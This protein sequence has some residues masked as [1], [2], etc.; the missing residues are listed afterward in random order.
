[1]TPDQQLF[2]EFVRTV[3][4]GEKRAR[5]LSIEDAREAMGLILDG[6]A[7]R[8][9]GAAFLLAL[10]IKGEDPAEVA[11][12]AQAMMERCAAAPNLPDMAH[13]V[14]VGHP[15]DGREDTFVMGAGAAIVAAAAGGRVV[16]HGAPRVPMKHAPTVGEVLL[17]L[18][19]PAYVKPDG[20]AETLSRFGFVHLSTP[21]FLPSWSAQL[22]LREKIGLRLPFS[23]VEKLLDP[24]RTGNLIVGIAH[25]P[26]LARIAGA[27]RR[28]NMR[29][30]LVI[31]GLEGSCDISPQHPAR[32]A[33]AWPDPNPDA[34]AREISVDPAALAINPVLNVRA[35]GADPQK[36]AE[37]TRHALERRTD[38]DSRGAAEAIALNAAILIWR[39]GLS[40][41]IQA[42]LQRA[43]EA[44]AS[45]AA[46][47]RMAE[48]ATK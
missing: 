11:G 13:A 37:L 22:E 3:G 4:R 43:R 26:Y 28:L 24:L 29:Q 45:G 30:G 42:G 25:G 20:A 23:T 32:V 48:A 46:L 41:D 40:P 47:S 10:R 14:S 15:Y 5:S 17:A 35:I 21:D 33:E 16:L 1:M 7:D 2:R 19:V 38:T 39:A 34:A 8:E 36:S 6:R 31:Q 12:F 27:F 44:I 18:G 9:Q